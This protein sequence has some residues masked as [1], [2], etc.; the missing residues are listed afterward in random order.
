ML[1]NVSPL[2]FMRENVA[3]PE[4][5]TLTINLPV[6]VPDTVTALPLSVIFKPGVSTVYAWVLMDDTLPAISVTST[7][8][9]GV[10]SSA[11]VTAELPLPKV[12]TLSALTD[13]EKSDAFTL[14]LPELSAVVVCERF[15]LKNTLTVAPAS[16]VPVAKTSSPVVFRA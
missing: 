9:V 16:A 2:S 15:A 4:A 5:S 1:V 14:Q 8:I 3:V 10:V 6:A 11:N 7:L 12:I 13:A